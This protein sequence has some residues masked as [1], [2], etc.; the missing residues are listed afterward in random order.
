LSGKA[1]IDTFFV[2]KAHGWRL[3]EIQ[4]FLEANRRFLGDWDQMNV[5]VRRGFMEE[6]KL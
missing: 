2:Y 6:E 3:R 1:N 5:D 4:G